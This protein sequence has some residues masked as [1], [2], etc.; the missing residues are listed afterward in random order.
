MMALRST[1]WRWVVRI[2]GEWNLVMIVSNDV[3]VSVSSAIGFIVIYTYEC[4]V[5]CVAGVSEQTCSLRRLK[6]A[7]L[8]HPLSDMQSVTPVPSAS[9]NSLYCSRHCPLVEAPQHTSTPLR[10][11][12]FRS[13]L[14][15]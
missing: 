3:D 12:T 13:D 15:R 1:L 5:V 4:S 11:G 6:F 2:R 9:L 10:D 8:M 7:L 14:L